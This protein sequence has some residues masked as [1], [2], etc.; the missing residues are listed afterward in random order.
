MEERADSWGGLGGREEE[1]RGREVG[2]EGEG[3]SG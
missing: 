3:E 2:E 1:V